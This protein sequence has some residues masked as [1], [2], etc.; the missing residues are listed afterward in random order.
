METLV[1]FDITDDYDSYFSNTSLPFPDATNNATIDPP[2]IWPYQTS[3]TPFSGIDRDYVLW[4]SPNSSP[5]AP[6]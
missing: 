4:S 6:P 2:V 3:A 1:N 5:T